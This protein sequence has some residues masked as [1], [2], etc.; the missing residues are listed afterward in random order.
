MS[1]ILGIVR[2]EA[3]RTAEADLVPMREAMS[4]WGGDGEASW[5]GGS[6]ALA[7]LLQPVTRSRHGPAPTALPERDGAVVAADVRLHNRSELSGQLGLDPDR[8]PDEE[9]VLRAY[10]RWGTV[11]PKRL[12]GT[13]A[14][15]VW[16]DRRQRLFC[17]RDHAGFRPFNYWEGAAG[18]WRSPTSSSA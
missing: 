2:P 1:G 12:N 10:L 3:A 8:I 17:A 9:L 6:V 5:T 16:D 13:F 4:F 18:A 7:H 15:A 11:C 14:F